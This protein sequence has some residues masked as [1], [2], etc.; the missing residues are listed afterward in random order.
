MVGIYFY[1][2]NIFGEKKAIFYLRLENGTIYIYL[3][4]HMSDFSIMEEN[5]WN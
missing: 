1:G 3:A 4:T 5:K 2:F